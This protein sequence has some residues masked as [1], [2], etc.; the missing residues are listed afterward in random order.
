VHSISKEKVYKSAPLSCK[1]SFS[2]KV[3]EKDNIFFQG[4]VSRDFEVC[5]LV[6]IDI[7]LPE[8]VCLLLKFCF[9]V[10]FLFLFLRLSVQIVSLHCELIWAFRSYFRSSVL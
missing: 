6:S 1:S 9:H 8:H 10:E 2:G 7:P 3:A 5:F 4:I